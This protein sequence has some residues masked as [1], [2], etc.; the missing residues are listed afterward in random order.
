MLLKTK[1]YLGPVPIIT[2]GELTYLEERLSLGEYAVGPGLDRL[3]RSSTPLCYLPI[4]HTGA[5]LRTLLESGRYWA[6]P[7]EHA[8][9]VPVDVL[10]LFGI[11]HVITPS[12]PIIFIWL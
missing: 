5:F 7:G 10:G 2:F 4:L 3:S 11:M 1:G 8:P 9:L 6:G 12:R